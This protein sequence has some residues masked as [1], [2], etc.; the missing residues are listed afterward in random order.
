MVPTD[1]FSETLKVLIFARQPLACREAMGVEI[2]SQQVCPQ[3][4]RQPH[5][6]AL[7]A[8]QRSS[9]IMLR[10]VTESGTKSQNPLPVL[11]E[12]S[13]GANGDEQVESLPGHLGYTTPPCDSAWR[14]PAS[15]PTI[16]EQ[17]KKDAR[18]MPSQSECFY[19]SHG[20]C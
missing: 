6:S 15:T 20:R 3:S 8:A 5:S 18:L 17:S 19:N 9:F 4:I 2:D 16:A 13:L 12:A 7:L 14:E 1:K 11:P 10:N